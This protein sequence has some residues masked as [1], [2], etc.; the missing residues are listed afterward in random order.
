M[1]QNLTPHLDD[2][3]LECVLMQSWK[4]VSSYLRYH[5][6][7]ADTLGIDFHSLR[8]PKFIK[9]IRQ[10]LAAP[11]QWQSEPLELVPA[12]K[13]QHWT[14]RNEKWEPHDSLAG[15]MR[16][17]AHV[18]LR[19]QVVATAMLLCL[20]DR[21]ESALGDPR[22]SIEK[23]DNRRRVLAY[24]HRLF[25]DR[26]GQKLRHRWGSSKLYRLFFQDYQSFLK[27]PRIVAEPLAQYGDFMNEYEY[28]I[29]QSDLSKFYDRVRPSLLHEKLRRLQQDASEEQFFRLAERVLS[30]Q[31]ANRDAATT[32]ARQA[33]IDDFMSV[34]LPQGLVAS[35]FFANVVLT[36]FEAALRGAL[37]SAIDDAGKYILLDAC[38]YVDD[39]RLV[40]RVPR[41]TPEADI[42]TAF[43]DWA[44]K[45]L[46]ATAPGL[47]VEPDKTE[48]TVEGR[49]RRFLVPQARA[50]QRIQTEVSGGF[51][52]LHGTELIGAIEGFFHTQQRYSS[53]STPEDSGRTGLLVG[54]SDM[55]DET[56]SRFAAGR[57][58]RTFRSLRPLLPTSLPDA[59]DA[60]HEEG[61]D[62]EDGATESHRDVVLTREQLDERAKLFSALLIEEW[63]GN[64]AN[65]RLLRIAL[66][67]YP[68]PDFVSQVLAIL[69]PGWSDAGVRGPKREVRLYC[70]SEVFR[71][72]AT[73]T[74]I[75]PDGE[76][77]PDDL[78]VADYHKELI[79]EGV[80]ILT[81]YLEAPT[82][83][84]RFPWYLLQQVFLYLAARDAF[85]EA[86]AD[87]RASG[88]P[89]LAHYRLFAKYLAGAPP[90][91][92]EQRS[93]FF[94]IAMT[95]FGITDVR[96]LLAGK[97]VSEEF[98]VQVNELSPAVAARVWEHVGPEASDRLRGVAQ[99]LGLEAR[100]S[101]SSRPTVAD[102][103]AR[104][105]NPFWQ[106]E[107]V[108]NLAAWLM[109]QSPDV[110]SE[111]ITPWQVACLCSQE[112]SGGFG[113]VDP[114]SFELVRSHKTAAG[115]F[116]PPE[117]CESDEERQR[118]QIGLLL[119][120]AIRGTTAFDGDHRVLSRVS[121]L[122]YRRPVSHWEQQRYSSYQG[123][124][125]FGPAWIP[126]SSFTEDV[127]F[128]LL[129]W[130]GSG[131]GEAV[132]SIDVLTMQV[133]ERLRWHDRHRGVHSR[134]I[135]LDQRA[136]PPYEKPRGDWS[137]P[138]RVG[139]VQSVIP[140]LADFVAHSGDPEL[141]ADV[142][143]RRR[144]RAHLAALLEGVLQMVRVR[145]THNEQERL[146]GNLI[147]LL[148]LPELAVHPVDI[149]PL[150]VPFARANK[151][152]I[153]CG[154][155][156]HREAALMQPGAMRAPLINSCLWLI[157]EWTKAAGFQL[158]EIEQGKKH[159]AS[160]ELALPEQPVSFRP[161]QWLVRYEWSNRQ[162]DR[163]M[164]LSASVCFDATD[165]A[166]AADLRSRNDLYI[167]C[168]LN[169]DV[170]T[171]DRMSEGLHYHMFQGVMVVNNG[172]FGGSSFY[173]PYKSP[174]HRQVFHLHGQPQ[175]SIAFAEI[176]PGKL[177]N[178]PQEADT[179]HP[180]GKWKTP[181]A[182]L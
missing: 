78:V 97:T 115:L 116:Q 49:D 147:D 88:G 166:L 35:G 181:P 148:I 75:V 153:L 175:A 67:M 131:P 71:A 69:R 86:V 168:A 42:E 22:L 104:Q 120:F 113:V 8:I 3:Q 110:H 141:L 102:L 158:R 117:W 121:E 2:L 63:T 169:R 52:V 26:N 98:L 103:A 133:K 151:C 137:R 48:V 99:R 84:S 68:S 159:L 96:R 128:E 145:H 178:R 82:R 156:Y 72:G 94:G 160:D 4:K 138:F 123:R 143:F 36:D 142:H 90:V 87:L 139:I 162:Q 140:S 83:R 89:L 177:I 34:A 150:L 107:N 119:R 9:E 165:L 74:G 54:V 60:T 15:R 77:L 118:Y 152:M 174:Y 127:L 57:F 135:F 134:Q 157:P 23:P 28:A 5:S 171:F 53:S 163:P 13:T 43:I 12:P 38:Y 29:V 93:V 81:A 46:D 112:D 155:V 17:L 10:Q 111:P 19:D 16:P 64:P 58:R 24:G 41:G 18:A 66:D 125:A 11:E 126:L 21:V 44:R 62:G 92:L 144:Q 45:R 40:L 55:R 6:W 85:P 101:Q 149:R 30:W 109:D 100:V 47:R 56:A 173:M 79:R 32:Y 76:C 73:E 179:L 37:D 61:V 114:K 51:D 146:D 33:N 108:L 14:F 154:L 7:Y 59:A 1:K 172:E 129:R 106:E 27:R 20:A 176:D 124:S 65:V 25:C 50:A 39:M 91:S 70:L 161:A 136:S 132:R 170:G 31:W 105:R 130:P 164:T 182:N 180:T 122:T 167:V 95:G 80:A